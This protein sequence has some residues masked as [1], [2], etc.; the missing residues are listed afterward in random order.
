M[1]EVT[2]VVESLK[3]DRTG[4][5]L[6]NGKWYG[7][8]Q[9]LT[10]NKGDKVELA[11]DE[12]TKDSFGNPSIAHVKVLH[13]APNPYN[14]G[15]YKGNNQGKPPTAYKTTGSSF[16]DPDTQSRI[17]RSHAATLAESVLSRAGG[18]LKKATKEVEKVFELAEKIKSYT[19]GSKKTTPPS[20]TSDTSFGDEDD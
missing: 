17:A 3:K 2:G 11:L 10:L 14:N 7:G 16:N 8:S 19:E 4:L 18:D 15:S 5:K 6:D 13:K 1:S 9:G 12:A 20:T